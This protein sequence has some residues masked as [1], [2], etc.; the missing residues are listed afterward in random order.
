MGVPKILGSTLILEG[1]LGSLSGNP[2]SVR[3][4]RMV[5][6]KPPGNSDA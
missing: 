3:R 1:K 6:P 4:K 5:S 2:P